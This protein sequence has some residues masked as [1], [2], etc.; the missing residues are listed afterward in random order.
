MIDIRSPEEEDH[1]PLELDGIKVKHLPFYKLATQF[2]DLPKGEDY[3]LYC[4]KGVMR[5][6]QALI[7][8]E[9]GYTNVKV[10]RPE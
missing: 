4:K 9:E 10:Y 8:H 3:Y 2:G 1:D 6:L 7:L 5:Q